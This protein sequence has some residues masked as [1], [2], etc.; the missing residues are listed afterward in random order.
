MTSPDLELARERSHHDACRAA[1]TRMTEDVA[2]Q[3]V[4]GEAAASA[5]PR[6]ARARPRT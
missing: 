2:G 5:G 3:V 1:L 6:T 4:T